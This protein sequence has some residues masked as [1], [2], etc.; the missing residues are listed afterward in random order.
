MVAMISVRKAARKLHAPERHIYYL[1][2]MGELSGTKVRWVWRLW[3]KEVDEYAVCR[4]A[5]RAGEDSSFDPQYYGYLFYLD[6]IT[7]HDLQG[8]PRRKALGLQGGRGMERAQIRSA[9]VHGETV[10]DL[11][12]NSLFS[13]FELFENAV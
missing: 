10:D 5:R 11:N 13:S 3:E 7:G 1:I 2:D 6:G 4:A 9:R 12:Q 8:N